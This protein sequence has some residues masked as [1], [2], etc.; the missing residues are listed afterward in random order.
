MVIFDWLNTFIA[1]LGW[2]NGGSYVILTLFVI[3][4]GIWLKSRRFPIESK[5][6]NVAIANNEII[7]VSAKEFLTGEQKLQISSEVVNYFY[8]R[9]SHLKHECGV[10]EYL[11]FFKLPPRIAVNYGNSDRLTSSIG[12]DMLMWG[13]IRSQ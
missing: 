4:L 5:K 12:V 10:G 7:N 8:A 1:S 13:T 6:I 11:N 2:D 9:L 3:V